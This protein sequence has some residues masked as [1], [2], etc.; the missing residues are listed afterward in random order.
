MQ[1][2]HKGL[3]TIHETA[4]RTPI[5]TLAVVAGIGLVLGALWARRD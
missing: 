5:E 2:A 3:D 4:V 1:A